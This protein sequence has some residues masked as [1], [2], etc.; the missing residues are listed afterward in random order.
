M[1]RLRKPLG[2]SLDELRKEGKVPIALITWEP[3][4]EFGIYLAQDVSAEDAI[5]LLDKLNLKVTLK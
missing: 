3:G 2:E 1:V 4:D 5:A